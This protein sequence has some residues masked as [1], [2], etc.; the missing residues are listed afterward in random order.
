MGYAM[1]A[2]LAESIKP[3]E[4]KV[5]NR[6]RARAEKLEEESSAIID[7]CTT[8]DELVSTTDIIFICLSDDGALKS[9]IDTILNASDLKGKLVCDMSSKSIHLVPIEKDSPN[10]LYTLTQQEAKQND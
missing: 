1:S 2:N 6:T 8:I 9:S 5:F 4:L 3:A 7:V 10:Q